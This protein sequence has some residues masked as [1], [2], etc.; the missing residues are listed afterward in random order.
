MK[1]CV[2]R[3]PDH[4]PA[5]DVGK[6]VEHVRR[7]HPGAT[8]EV[9]LPEG[10]DDGGTQRAGTVQ[11]YRHAGLATLWP[12]LR[13]LRTSRYDLFV[14]LFP[15]SKL[16]LIAAA[17]GARRKAVLLQNGR[18]MPLTASWPRALVIESL[19]LARGRLRYGR[20]WLSVRLRHVKLT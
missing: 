17:C 13:R 11:R 18:L 12:L 19:L 9:L 10:D 1:I 14:V 15:S 4:D 16:R 6:A 2:F 8:L 20:A 7:S 3:S 5:H